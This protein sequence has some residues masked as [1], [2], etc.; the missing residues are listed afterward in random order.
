MCVWW[1]W[2][3]M[4]L[5]V[6][7]CVCMHEL[8][9]PFVYNGCVCWAEEERRIWTRLLKP[10]SSGGHNRSRLTQRTGL[11]QVGRREGGWEDP[12]RASKPRRELEQH[13][14]KRRISTYDFCC[15]SQLRKVNY[16][17]VSTDSARIRGA[18]DLAPMSVIINCLW[19]ADWS[20][21]Q[22]RKR[23]YQVCNQQKP[24]C[25]SL[26]RTFIAKKQS[27]LLVLH[28]GDNHFCRISTVQAA[29]RNIQSYRFCASGT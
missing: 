21:L 28:I 3:W 19:L 10:G 5:Y 2:W 16:S 8:P 27:N 17:C 15:R 7:G 13:G 6:C 20:I 25:V 11:Q 14:D 22:L 9:A 1:W 4:C 26:R 12:A 24:D 23:F 18:T 29:D